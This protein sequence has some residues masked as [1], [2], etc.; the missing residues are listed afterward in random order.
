MLK[1]TIEIELTA[2]K[3]VGILPVL[4]RKINSFGLIYRRCNIQEYKGGVKLTLISQGQLDCDETVLVKALKE[5]PNVES[6]L[7]VSQ[8]QS[9]AV[10]PFEKFNGKINE[11]TELHP[12]RAK[13]PITQ[14]VMHV[15]E[16]RL[17][18]VFGPSANLLIKSAAKKSTCVGQLFLI[19]AKS[20]NFDQKVIFL[21]NIEDLEDLLPN[22]ANRT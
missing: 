10:E 7:N 3:R 2:S 16:D 22:E 19:L 20:L 13:D 5:V 15:V 21:R 14:D 11:F 18:E 12:L 9:K 1:N 4:M 8:S 6:V 17:A